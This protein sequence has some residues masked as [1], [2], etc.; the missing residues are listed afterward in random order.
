[1]LIEGTKLFDEAEK[2]AANDPVALDQV[3]RARLALEYVQLMRS[4]PD[5][6]APGGL[7]HEA[8]ADRVAGKVKQYGIGQIREGEPVAKFL[9]RIGKK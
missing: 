6:P 2:A 7:T 9:E 1:M 4:K 8:L 3:Q 5:K